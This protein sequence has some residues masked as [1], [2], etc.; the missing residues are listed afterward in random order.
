M[1]KNKFSS[2]YA[3][4]ISSIVLGLGLWT[5]TSTLL[6]FNTNAE[7]RN[8][9]KK[10]STE[11]PLGFSMDKMDTTVSPR[12]DFHRFAAGKWLDN[13]KIPPDK[14]MVY[15]LSLLDDRV[16]QQLQQ[17][18]A[19]A[20]TQSATAPKG[21]PLQQV[22]DLYAGGMDV[23]RLE[24]L[25]VSPLKPIFDRIA[26]I[27]S[28]PALAKTLP[29]LQMTLSDPIILGV[30]VT[31]DLED[32][33]TN[34]IGL[35]GGKLSLSSQEDYL[36]PDKAAI[37]QA[38]LDYVTA[39]LEIA[40]SSPAEATAAAKKILEMETRI[41]SKQLSPVEKRDIQK[42]MAKMSF[43]K[44]QSLLSNLDMKIYFQELGLPTT[45]NVLVED[46][47]SLADLNQM[48]KQYSIDDIKTYLRW[49]FL[50]Q[51]MSYLTPAF[52][53]PLLAFNKVYYGQEFQ[54]PPRTER[55]TN[56]IGQ[57]YGHPLSQLYVKEHF[58]PES[59]KQVEEMIQQIKSLFR[60]R[61]V[62]NKWLTEPTRKYAVEKLDRIVIKVGYP[63][64]W[65]DYSSIDIRRDDFFGNV[66]RTSEFFNRRELSKLGKPVT[67]DDFDDPKGTL[68]IQ[69]N[70]AYSPDRNN[71]Q[72]PAAFLQPPNYDPK[73]DA[74][75]NFCSM[76]AVIG[77]E[78]THGFDS[79]GRQFDAQGNF[80]NWW[81]KEDATKFEAQTDKLVKQANA[82]EVL[83]GL[84][85]NGQLSVG[86][87]LADV[88]GISLAYEALKD[89]LKKNP[90]ANKKIDGYTP[91]QRCFMAWSQLWATKINEGYLRQVTLTD[92]HPVGAYR[93]FAPFQH[94]AGFFKAFGIKPGDRMWMDEKDRVNIW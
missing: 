81:T 70:A 42:A 89:Y 58:S 9:G 73:A 50:R 75:L 64:K 44:L 67:F 65:I 94:E 14:L 78:M 74:A 60:G 35:G 54:L 7:E 66:M 57:K 23:K 17:I 69:I 84:K 13:T 2:C 24:S 55:V 87:N 15:G 45:G 41:A 43:A 83:P 4:L 30:G 68:P 26:A 28:P 20:A 63:E 86:E 49:G 77:H 72:I 76:G 61:L 37:R 56:L 85:L 22:G 90:Q 27:D 46:S 59:K 21:S 33:K 31:G 40:G 92:G 8:A 80:K 10:P 5:G 6:L 34:I 51:N 36:S 11:F 38:Y 1:K 82:F 39:A 53:K 32:A 3:Q 93:G 47:G 52:E 16:S 19:Q 18:T 12:Q 25:G 71:I 79:M 91:E 62:A 29:Q 88:G 48:L